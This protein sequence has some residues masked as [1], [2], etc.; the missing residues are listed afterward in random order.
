MNNLVHRVNITKVILKMGYSIDNPLIYTFFKGKTKIFFIFRNQI[1][2]KSGLFL[3]HI[4][5]L[6]AHNPHDLWSHTGWS[7]EGIESV[8]RSRGKFL[9]FLGKRKFSQWCSG[10]KIKKWTKIYKGTG[11]P[12]QKIYFNKVTVRLLICLCVPPIIL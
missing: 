10:E 3:R 2:W 12:K 6:V 1:Q 11:W 5:I 4:P 8:V 7:H 9:G